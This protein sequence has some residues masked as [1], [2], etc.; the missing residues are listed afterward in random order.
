MLRELAAVTLKA[1]GPRTTN[2]AVLQSSQTL[3]E[4]TL[5]TLLSSSL[6]SPA[7]REI[8]PLRKKKTQERQWVII[9]WLWEQ[10]GSRLCGRF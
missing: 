4:A 10:G 1:A 6:R 8:V 9:L 5:I 2:S 7:Y 3:P